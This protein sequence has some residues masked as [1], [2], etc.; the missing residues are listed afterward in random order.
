MVGDTWISD[1]FH[2]GSCLSRITLVV[3]LIFLMERSSEFWTG[4]VRLQSPFKRYI[5]IY[6]YIYIYKVKLVLHD[7]TLLLYTKVAS[8]V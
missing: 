1:S 8:N 5:Y 7:P 2:Q 6:I 4:Y 3:P